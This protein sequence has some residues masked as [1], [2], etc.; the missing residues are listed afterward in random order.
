MLDPGRK[1]AQTKGRP[2]CAWPCVS[3]CAKLH[4]LVLCLVQP[5]KLSGWQMQGVPES[6]RASLVGQLFDLADM[7]GD[8]ALSLDEFS[9]YYYRDLVLRKDLPS[10]V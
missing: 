9:Y 1:E 7:D 10:G 3:L 2:E 8:D 5:I 4:A 6:H